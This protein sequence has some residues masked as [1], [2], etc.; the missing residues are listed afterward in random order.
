MD[1]FLEA[2]EQSDLRDALGDTITEANQF[3][4]T[5][6]N[7]VYN[8]RMQ[9]LEE[10]H[11]DNM[12]KIDAPFDYQIRLLEEE[13][14][15]TVGAQNA[16]N[17]DANDAFYDLNLRLDQFADDLTSSFQE[18]AD[19]IKNAI[20]RSFLDRKHPCKVLAAL[21][22]DW[23]QKK[24][25]CGFATTDPDTITEILVNDADLPK[26]YGMYDDLFSNFH[27]DI[28]HGK[29]T[30]EGSLDMAPV[31]DG[32]NKGKSSGKVQGDRQTQYGQKTGVWELP[33]VP[34]RRF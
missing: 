25:T 34:S 13:R 32:Y 18:E 24:I 4:I 8:R 19:M 15:D 20:S 3:R 11:A 28:G 31:N 10:I 2:Q 17:K 16:S 33:G 22:I 23:L 7:F 21:R 12:F 14:G 30:G 6:L 27:Y 9:R 26:I 1:H 29:G 5:Y